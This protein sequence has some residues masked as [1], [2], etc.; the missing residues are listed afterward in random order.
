LVAISCE[1]GYWKNVKISSEKAQ[2]SCATRWKIR[3]KRQW[4]SGVSVL[5]TCEVEHWKNVKNESE[6]NQN[7]CETRW[8]I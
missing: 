2:N 1:I 4:G 7:S 8:K 5:R 3:V 6:K